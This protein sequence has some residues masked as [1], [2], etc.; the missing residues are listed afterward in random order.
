MDE[1][2]LPEREATTV[3]FTDIV[4]STV[5]LATLGDH[6]WREVLTTHDE[7]IGMNSVRPWRSPMS[8]AWM[9]TSM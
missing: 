1:H 8:A 2:P 5:S 4:G 6:S 3:M 9:T 7:L